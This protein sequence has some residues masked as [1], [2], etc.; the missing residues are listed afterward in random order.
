MLQEKHYRYDMMIEVPRDF[1]IA[2]ALSSGTSFLEPLQCG[3]I[4]TMGVHKAWA[5]SRSYGLV[6]K[7]DRDY[8]PVA[9]LHSRADGKRHGTTCA[10]EVD[11]RL[12]VASK[13]GGCILAQEGP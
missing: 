4:R 7:L 1:W 2:P 13:G 3:G 9:S 5:P 6:A 8:A 12:L 10:I 11:G